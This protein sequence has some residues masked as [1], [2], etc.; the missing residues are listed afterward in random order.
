MAEKAFQ[1]E[2]LNARNYI[3]GLDVAF[4]AVDNALVLYL[5]EAFAAMELDTCD[6]NTFET[7]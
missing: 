3:R 2:F 7:H 6:W 4:V 5:F 1:S